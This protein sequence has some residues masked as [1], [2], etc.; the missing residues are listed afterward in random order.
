MIYSWYGRETNYKLL[1]LLK[2]LDSSCKAIKLEHNY[3]SQQSKM[4]FFDTLIYKFRIT[5]IQATAK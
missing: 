3:I 1:T 5:Y 4:P 2:N